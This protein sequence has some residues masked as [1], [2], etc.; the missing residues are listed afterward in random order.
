MS[1]PGAQAFVAPPSGR[2]RARGS[3]TIDLAGRR[4]NSNQFPGQAN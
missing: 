1:S 3:T 2:P 4:C